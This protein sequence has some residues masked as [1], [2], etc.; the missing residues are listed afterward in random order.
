MICS[1]GKNCSIES[2]FMKATVEITNIKTWRR[3][4]K[5]NTVYC[6]I[7]FLTIAI[8]R[9]FIFLPSV[10]LWNSLSLRSEK[11]KHFL[12]RIHNIRLFHLLSADY[13]F[14]YL[15][16]CISCVPIVDTCH[17]VLPCIFLLLGYCKFYKGILLAF[18][19]VAI[20]ILM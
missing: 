20:V 11:G 9:N 18:L 1:Y 17:I 12:R 4:F 13:M 14:G 6:I 8:V 7:Y 15:F 2:I 3:V 16:L 5:T 19:R 10:V